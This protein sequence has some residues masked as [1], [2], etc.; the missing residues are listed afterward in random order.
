MKK[1]VSFVTALAMTSALWTIPASAADEIITIN[2]V[3]ANNDRIVLTVDDAITEADFDSAVML[4]KN[5][6]TQ[7]ITTKISTATEE[8][9]GK[10]TIEII[11]QDGIADNERYDLNVKGTVNYETAFKLAPN[12]NTT[13]PALGGTSAA[14][15][16][17]F[18]TGSENTGTVS[19]ELKDE[20]ENKKGFRVAYD[21]TVTDNG[22]V[23]RII[24]GTQW[25]SINNQSDLWPADFAFSVDIT[26]ETDVA[27]IKAVLKNYSN[28]DDYNISKTQ[29]PFIYCI[30]NSGSKYNKGNVYEDKVGETS[31]GT[32]ITLAKNKTTHLEFIAKGDNIKV[33]ADGIK[34]VDVSGCAVENGYTVIGFRNTKQTVRVENM[35]T[36]TF[37]ELEAISDVQAEN[38]FI[39]KDAINIV[40]DNEMYGKEFVGNAIIKKSG[41]LQNFT[42]KI[43]GKILSL[44]PEGGISPGERYDVKLL[45][46]N[47][48][49]LSELL[50]DY[51]YQFK[52][53]DLVTDDFNLYNDENPITNNWVTEN[54]ITIT[55]NNGKGRV[56]HL[57][58]GDNYSSTLKYKNWYSGF[59]PLAS[60]DHSVS[61]DVT[62]ITD[63]FRALLFAKSNAAHRN[64]GNKFIAT[65]ANDTGITIGYYES[66]KAI[67]EVNVPKTLSKN[68]TYHVTLNIVGNKAELF[69]DGEYIGEATGPENNEQ[70]SVDMYSYVNKVESTYD[71]DNF[72]ISTCEELEAISD[73]QAE[74][75]FISKDAINIVMD[76]EMYGK[77]FVGNA[78]IKK[79]GELQNFTA[80]INGKILSLMPE[81]GIS[82][83]ER[84]DV[85]LLSGNID[86]LSELLMDYEYQ[87]KQN[88]LVTDDFNLYNDENPITNN[89]VTENNITITS[90]NGKGRVTHLASGDNYSSTLKYKNWYSGFK[91]LA[92][93]DHSV[94]VDVT[95]I[96]DTFRALLFAKSNA[97]HRNIGNKFI[98]TLA[99]DTGITIG[100]YESGK[101]INEV[102]VPKTLSK[103][104]TYHV[105]LNIVGNKAELFVDGEYIGEATGPENNEQY[106]VDMYSYVSKVESTYDIDNFSVSTCE[107][108]TPI[109]DLEITG[110]TLNED[111]IVIKVN[112]NLDETSAYVEAALKKNGENVKYTTKVVQDTIL[113]TPETFISGVDYELTISKIRDLNAETTAEYVEKF[114]LNRVFADNFDSYTQQKPVE[115]IYDIKNGTIAVEQEELIIIPTADS[116]ELAVKES[117]LDSLNEYTVSFDL[118]RAS[119]AFGFITYVNNKDTEIKIT[120]DAVS[121]KNGSDSAYTT[122]TFNFALD[123][124]HNVKIVTFANYTQVYVDNELIVQHENA[125]NNVGGVAFYANNNGAAYK[126]DNLLVSAKDAA[127]GSVS[128]T[129]T[130]SESDGKLSGNITASNETQKD[131]SGIIIVASY[132]GE[133]LIDIKVMPNIVISVGQ[134]VNYDNISINGAGGNKSVK[135]MLWNGIDNMIPYCGSTN[136]VIK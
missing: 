61:V 42:A 60:A 1:I 98:A 72:S 23:S 24:T 68:N 30:D 69:V 21:D 130:F 121:I 32:G 134:S 86:N 6:Q 79:S 78:I 131:I 75:Q 31:L 11:P 54:N 105:T 67:N 7:E 13:I 26:P 46:G 132:S 126:L 96:T 93:A 18:Y 12:A 83:G 102:N 25:Q 119:Q 91:P 99:N 74:N 65:L 45:S 82:P 88:D 116:A 70:Y 15:G 104:N 49:N 125:D 120:S 55:S 87:F 56:T 52:Q 40:M 115:N 117:K 5:G 92:S 122:G 84:Y 136:A 101:A 114:L 9:G 20:N 8:G 22:K 85:K 37:T 39:S 62:P 124:S 106:S 103:N 129:G 38:Q 43:N 81:G 111:G 135:L 97:A 57:A 34:T 44:M 109:E 58:S 127:K 27:S 64:I 2:S 100:Y 113:I 71:I 59:K 80:K 4:K 35:K 14:I 63:T 66:G 112:K 19:E 33:Y 118:T 16:W 17:K 36:T 47:I 73:V 107:K 48:D 77:E 51:E 50:M 123:S 10:T 94:S 76:N 133:Q 89:W 53:N 29:S 28:R 90:N 95:P 108:L 41:E 3:Y 128:L 110:T